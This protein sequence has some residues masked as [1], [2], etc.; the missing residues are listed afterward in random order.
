MMITDRAFDSKDVNAIT[1]HPIDL[2]GDHE[3]YLGK[4]ENAIYMP[5]NG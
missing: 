5:R 2:N 1:W 4:E 3:N